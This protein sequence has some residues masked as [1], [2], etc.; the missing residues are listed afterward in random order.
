M[1]R[2]LIAGLLLIIFGLLVSPLP[3]QQAS[4]GEGAAPRQWALTDKLPLD[5]A[6][7]TG[8]LENGLTYYVRR[9]T[10]P[11]NRAELRLAVNAGAT[12]EDDDQKGLAH[13][14]E[15]MLF[16]GT[17]R[18]E[19]SALVDFLEG[20][21][22]RFGPD[23]NAYTSFD[24]TVY[25]LR[26]PT[27]KPELLSRAFDVLE[28]WA[29]AAAL[30]AEEIEKERGVVIEEW[31]LGQGAQ[32]R[33]RDKLIPAIFA[34]SRYKDRLPIGDPEIIRN[35][36]REAFTRFYTD[37]YRPSLMAVVAVGDFDPAAVE[38]MIRERFSSLK[39]PEK[40]R[41]RPE[42]TLPGHE[43]T[44]FA[45]VTDPELPVTQV[46]VFFKKEQSEDFETVA[47][48]RRLLVRSIFEG[49]INT[50][51]A[52][53]TRKPD[54]PFLAAGISS[55]SLVRAGHTYA[56]QAIAK[57]GMV[58]QSLETLFTEVARVREH[59]LTATEIERQK[60]DLLRGYEQMYQERENTNSNG[61]AREYVSN[62]LEGE[63]APGIAVEYQLARQLV[64]GITLEELNKTAEALITQENRVVVVAM[65]E[66]AGL[67]PPSQE[68][69]AKV[70][71][72]VEA[73]DLEP[74]TDNVLDEPL[75]SAELQPAPV[76]S[77]RKVEALGV[78][79]TVL[80]NGVKILTRPTDFK[81]EEVLFTAFSDGGSSL[82]PDELYQD[83]QAADAVISLS[84]LGNF[85]AMALEKKLAGK[86]VRVQPSIG[87]LGEELRGSAGTP[88]LESL[89]QLVHLYFTAPR[90]EESALQVYKQQRMAGLQNLL[91]TPQGVFQ[92]TMLDVMFGNHPRRRIPT[93]QEVQ[94]TSL[95]AVAKIY[96]ERF[97]DAS[98]FTFLFVGSFNEAQL[99]EM[100]QL[101]LGSLPT[102][103]GEEQRKETWKDVQPELPKGI[104]KGV[105]IK[106]TDPQS[107]VS[108]TFHGSMEY[109]RENRFRLRMMANV[110]NIKL[111]EE[112]REDR[113]GV[114]GV[115][116]SASPSSRPRGEYSMRISFSCDP[117]RVK[118]LKGA[119]MEQITWIQ[120]AE[121][122]E[123]YLAK[124]RE[125]ERR[126]FETSLRENRFWLSTIQFYYEHPDEDPSLL[127]KLPETVEA[128][129]TEQIRETAKKYIDTTRYIDVTLYPENFEI[130]G[131]AKP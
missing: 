120:N 72:T 97:A 12:L 35:A 14:L 115:S 64:P 119:V 31:R 84:G 18:F 100:C 59:G 71:E 70:L 122:L 51:L 127:L 73:R 123:S 129:G 130:P 89:L 83:A 116:V 57:E 124:V 16:N 55:S 50:R 49:A 38:A 68:A 63:P 9:N 86:S 95:E 92:K 19:K 121:D 42:Y 87:E 110:L 128:I 25:M 39:N 43:E 6:I 108:L 90:A 52:E 111:R 93:V 10:Q 24:E 17:K 36:P 98:D 3:S 62:F 109:N 21:G 79:E 30:E 37:W 114:Y 66:K 77:Q 26:V 74:Y 80:A 28:D 5:P 27:D 54:A 88:D 91:S 81:Q 107:R 103:D 85:D 112:L 53:I 67:V 96:Q 20:I 126:S 113:G 106:G 13:F 117:N 104:A 44:I 11:R 56:A 4:Q 7:R 76:R 78:T 60:A 82:V 99:L 1:H 58:L 61:F 65:P 75:L 105:A 34:G 40:P 22:L 47:D 15:H 48:Y 29:G 2:N 118:E 101:Y 94:G 131:E 32:G 69:L 102:Q 46:Q 23:L 125:Q 33:L 41:E 8:K 45:T